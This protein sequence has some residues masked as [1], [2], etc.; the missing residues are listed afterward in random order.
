MALVAIF[1][2][3]VFKLRSDDRVDAFGTSKNVETV[4]DVGHHC[5]I[6]RANLVLL[7]TSQAA[8]AHRQNVIDL[9]AGEIVESV[10]LDASGGIHVFGIVAMH[11]LNA[12]ACKLLSHCHG[13]APAVKLIGSLSRRLCAADDADE[14]VKIR[15]RN[16]LT[17]E[18]M[19]LRTV[20]AQTEDRT[21]RHHFAAVRQEVHDHL[22]QVEKR[23]LAIY[24]GDHVHA[25]ALLHL[26]H[27]EE[28]VE[29]DLRHGALLEIDADADVLRGLITH[30]C[31]A[32]DLFLAHELVHLLVHDALV[33]HVRNLVD[34]DADTVATK[35]LEMRAGAHDH[36]ASPRPIALMH[37]RDAEDDAARRKVRR[38]HQANEIL[39]R[40]L[41]MVKLMQAGI[42]RL[43][44][45]VRRDVRGHAH[46]DAGRAVDEKLGKTGRQDDGLL[47]GVVEVGNKIDGV[48]IDVGKHFGSDLFETHFRVTHGGRAIPVDRAEVA[49]AEDERIAQR[50]RLSHAHDSHV[51]G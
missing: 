46:G 34:D 43:A 30:F 29:H 14:F 45:I 41:R 39:D 7:E 12:A 25:K 23:R 36:P 19:S 22:L 49:L 18:Q 28:I 13:P 51:R 5:G 3:N 33:D 6:V 31:D 24:E 50:K 1:L 11:L 8:Q 2:S 35:V 32:L 9:R 37:V 10:G 44:E 21:A 48:L 17:F 26:R 4:G 38:R 40:T 15:K 16:R 20:L 27:L 42:N 47:F